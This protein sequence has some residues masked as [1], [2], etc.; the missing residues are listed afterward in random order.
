MSNVAALRRV[1]LAITLAGSAACASA[2]PSEEKGGS[3]AALSDGDDTSTPDVADA[4]SGK[5]LTSETS[6]KST[7]IVALTFDGGRLQATAVNKGY[8]DALSATRVPIETALSD[9]RATT[10]VDCT[11]DE[12]KHQFTFP[13]SEA[14]A[15]TTNYVYQYKL[16]GAQLVIDDGTKTTTFTPSSN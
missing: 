5:Y 7:S 1:V 8:M 3:S 6:L 15:G 10:L 14:F 13:V 11:I 4:P 16:D 9:V 12:S 2:Q